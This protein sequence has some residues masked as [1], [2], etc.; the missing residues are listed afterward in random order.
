MRYV[1]VRKAKKEHFIGFNVPADLKD[2]LEQV[3]KETYE[4][5]L[6]EQ[7]IGSGQH[8]RIVEEVKDNYKRMKKTYDA[9][10]QMGK[11]EESIIDEAKYKW[12]VDVAKLEG[13]LQA[14]IE[15]LKENGYEI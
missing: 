5:F 14:I 12:W 2:E 7:Q 11:P 1:L 3:R 13:G 6:E 8:Q 15:I 9:K 4:K 10:K